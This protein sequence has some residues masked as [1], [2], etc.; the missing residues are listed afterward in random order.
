MERRK[1]GILFSG[2]KD[3]CLALHKYG[4]E[5]ADVLLTMLS[6]NK[7][8]FMFHSPIL[9]LLKKQAERL[10][11]PLVIEETNGE[12]EKEMDDLKRLIK[13]SEVDTIVSGGIKSSYQA[14]RIRKV[15]EELNVQIELPLWDYTS[16]QL[17][18]ELLG[19]G[20]KVVITK[21]A[22]EGIHREFIGQVIDKSLLDELKKL[23]KKY[24]F[25][26]D[27]EGG[28]AETAVIWM[29]GFKNEIK[30]DYELESEGEYRHFLCLK[31]LYA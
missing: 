21:I 25:R 7:D 26:M 5:K 8:S 30:L 1:I 4:L 24:K 19:E 22:S 28:D 17:W 20:F 31:K 15:C 2:G 13:K 29:P 23:S 9:P 14:K 27:F 12:E 16:E 6:K 18:D 11:L 3:S 10:A